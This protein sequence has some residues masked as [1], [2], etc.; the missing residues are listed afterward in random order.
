[1]VIVVVEVV[2][3]VIVVVEVVVVVIVVVEVVVVVLVIVVVVVSCSSSFKFDASEHVRSTGICP[4]PHDGDVRDR[5][6]NV[7]YLN[8]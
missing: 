8:T 1:M 6:I 5:H 3:V 2:A 7:L 4:D